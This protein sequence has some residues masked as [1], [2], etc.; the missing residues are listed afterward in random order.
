MAWYKV[1][2]STIQCNDGLSVHWLVYF[3][4]ALVVFGNNHGYENIGVT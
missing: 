2:V 3:H 1:F 4:N